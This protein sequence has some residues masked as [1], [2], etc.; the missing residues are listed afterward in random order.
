MV[1]P[2]PWEPEGN[3]TDVTVEDNTI[4]GGYATQV[5]SHNMACCANDKYGNDTLGSNN[6]SAIIKIGI[7]SEKMLSSR[8]SRLIIRPSDLEC[9]SP[10]EPSTS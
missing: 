3:F 9:G 5:G 8:V 6:A 10:S 7:V 1:D 2:L 4:M